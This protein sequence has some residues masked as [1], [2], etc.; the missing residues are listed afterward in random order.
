MA[1][2]AIQQCTEK[3][4]LPC[5]SAH[6]KI[7]K[8]DFAGTRIYCQINTS[9]AI[10]VQQILKVRF[11]HLVPISVMETLQ[12]KL[13]DSKKFR[14][15]EVDKDLLDF[16]TRKRAKV[17]LHYRKVSHNLKNS[18]DLTG[19]WGCVVTGPGMSTSG[20]QIPLS[21]CLNG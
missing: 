14:T 5:E 6:S 11:P 9:F 16:L 17:V 18:C 10:Q 1:A 13:K 3:E 21:C 15:G 20:H 7:D 2:G 12:Q 8:R 19:P 4:L